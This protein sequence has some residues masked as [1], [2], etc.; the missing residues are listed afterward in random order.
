MRENVP[1]LKRRAKWYNQSDVKLKAD[2][3]VWVT[4]P[5]TPL[6]RILRLHY[7][8]D[9]C[10]RSAD[11]K[12]ITS[13]LT[14]P[15]LSIYTVLIVIAGASCVFGI[16]SCHTAPNNATAKLGWVI[17]RMAIVVITV[18]FMLNF[19]TRVVIRMRESKRKLKVEITYEKRNSANQ[20]EM[21]PIP[22]VTLA[23][24]D[25]H[26]THE[27]RAP[28]LSGPSSRRSSQQVARTLAEDLVAE[29]DGLEHRAEGSSKR[30][31]L[32][33]ETAAVI[34]NPEPI[35]E[36]KEVRGMESTLRLHREN[37]SASSLTTMD[38]GIIVEEE[39]E[40]TGST[41]KPDSLS[42]GNSKGLDWGKCTKF[43]PIQ[44]ARNLINRF[45][46]LNYEKK[47]TVLFI[48]VGVA[49]TLLTIPDVILQTMDT[50]HSE[51]DSWRATFNTLQPILQTVF[52]C[53]FT[54]NPFIYY[55]MNSYF[56]TRV[57]NLINFRC[58]NWN[59]SD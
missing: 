19:Y 57:M 51:T 13:E 6:A 26:A 29:S 56:R 31:S 54:I 33:T 8:K 18:A 9:G 15:T 49:F 43:G 10:A 23:S 2:D 35:Q 11:I 53:N 5:D 58:S 21:A 1:S 38:G 47:L 39:E 7:G 17:Q 3:L 36:M 12:T 37:K 22:N 20:T 52:C 16:I 50:L 45:S 34:Q 55:T 14:R 24:E 28:I 59:N 4:E 25:I 27:E 30:V 40:K 44:A 48:C 41:C 46:N 42:A 32:V